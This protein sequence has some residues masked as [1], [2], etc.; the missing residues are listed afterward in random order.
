MYKH[1]QIPIIGKAIVAIQDT[2]GRI[3]YVSGWVTDGE[4]I[5]DYEEKDILLDDMGTF[6]RE[7]ADRNMHVELDM[8]QVNWRYHEQ[9]DWS[10]IPD[11]RAIE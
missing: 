6:A 10:D 3:F 1:Q 8:T 4:M 2:H 9:P 7:I 5:V 11:P